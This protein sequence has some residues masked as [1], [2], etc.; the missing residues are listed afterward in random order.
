MYDCNDYRGICLLNVSYKLFSALINKRL[1]RFC[2]ENGVLEDEQ[3]GFREGRGSVDQIYS[4]HSIVAERKARGVDSFVCFLDVK[5]ASDRVWSWS[6]GV[7][8]G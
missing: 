7:S 5:K 2:V 4:L 3:G 1:V 6:L 8:R